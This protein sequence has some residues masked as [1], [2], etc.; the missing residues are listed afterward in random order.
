MANN[1][2]ECCRVARND[3]IKLCGG[4]IIDPRRSPV[5]IGISSSE[6][7]R[8]AAAIGAR[9]VQRAVLQLL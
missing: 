9:C 4:R 5:T 7:R 1:G 6:R 3:D 2:A 8:S